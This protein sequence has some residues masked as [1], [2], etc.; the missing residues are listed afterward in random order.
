[1]PLTQCDGMADEST[2]HALNILQFE[3]KSSLA[4]VSVRNV[5]TWF[6][7]CMYKTDETIPTQFKY[8]VYWL[9]SLSDADQDNID[10]YTRSYTKLV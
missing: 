10:D 6:T 9:V 1:M 8:T 7:T 3:S 5:M 4:S 2:K